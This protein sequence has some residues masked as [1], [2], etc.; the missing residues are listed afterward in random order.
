MKIE[1]VLNK[2]EKIV[3]T[4]K[5]DF[6]S[7]MLSSI[8]Y[9]PIIPIGIFIF[10]FSLP[11]VIIGLALFLKHP[12]GLNLIGLNLG[13]EEEYIGAQIFGLIFFLLGCIPFY[14]GFVLTISPVF[15]W[16]GYYNLLF[17]FTNKRYIVKSGWF[18][19]NYKIINFSVIKNIELKVDFFDKI[20]NTGNILIFTSD[21]TFSED[22]VQ[23]GSEVIY[24]IK[25]PYKVLQIITDLIKV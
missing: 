23:T 15:F 6:V 2:D 13:N 5:P 3:Y 18:T 21:L 22:N 16:I 7:Y 12:F 9:I 8:Q 24:K 10:L 11:F 20:F 19:N 25:E 14:K 1:E 17:I 4:L